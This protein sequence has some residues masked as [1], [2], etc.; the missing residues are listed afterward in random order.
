M[1]D[2]DIEGRCRCGGYRFRAAA[3]PF[4]VSYCHCADCRRSTGAPVVVLLGFADEDVEILSGEAGT[5]RSSPGVER[6]FCPACGTPIA[7]RDAAL[8]GETYYYLGLFADPARFPPRVHAFVS[9]QLPWLDI[10][11]GL[12]RHHRFSRER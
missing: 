7:Y 12:P 8:P 3:G 5:Y 2:P 1:A 9:E 11:D 6:L 10:R 4:R